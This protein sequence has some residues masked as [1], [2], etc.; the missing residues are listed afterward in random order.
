MTVLQLFYRFLKI[1]N[2]YNLFFYNILHREYK[3]SWQYNIK[4]ITTCK[5]F[6]LI[7]WAFAWRETKEGYNFWSKFNDRWEKIILCY[8]TRFSKSETFD[9]LL[10]NEEIKLNNE[11]IKMLK[12]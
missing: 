6:F 8:A 1:N 10:S 3:S 2:I 4:N 9:S 11:L 7:N 12:V 5:S